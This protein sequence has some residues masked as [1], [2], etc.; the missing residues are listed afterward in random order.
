MLHIND[1]FYTIQGEGKNAGHAALFVR[2][3]FCNLACPWCD[4]EFNSFTKLS[5]EDFESEALKHI[6]EIKSN[7]D[8]KPIAVITGGE[9]SMNKHTPDV[10]RIL[11][12]LH[13]TI[14]MESNGQFLAPEGV[15]HLTISPKRWHNRD[16]LDASKAF[17]FN[18][19]NRPSEIKI[20]VDGEDA[21]S[22][23]DSIY[24]A[25]KNYK[26]VFKDDSHP[27]FFISP[28]WNEREKWL[29]KMTEYVMKNPAWRISLQTH[30]LLD[31]K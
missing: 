14:S 5:E 3:P 6:G 23:A 16:T 19:E 21:F 8:P 13:Y 27:L 30:K 7:T 11:K 24:I 31:V 15:D 29:P 9:P 2:M 26:F 22:A 4:T 10:I 17:Q 25:W 28:E 1:V 18:F 20:V 12:K